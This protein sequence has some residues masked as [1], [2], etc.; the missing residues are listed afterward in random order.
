MRLRPVLIALAAL[1]ALAAPI[2]I[3]IGIVG[4][5]GCP[6]TTEQATTTASISPAPPPAPSP[7]MA[8]TTPSLD[9][10]VEPE[11]A[12]PEPLDASFEDVSA[13]AP[14]DALADGDGRA[15]ADAAGDAPLLGAKTFA[16]ETAE[17]GFRYVT[18]A[19]AKVHK[20]PKDGKAFVS[21]PKG[22][23][24]WLVARLFD[25]YRVRFVDPSTEQ[26]RQGLIYLTTGVGPRRKDCPEGWIWHDQDGGWCEREC[27][28]NTDCKALP[29][30][31]CSGTGCFYAVV[32]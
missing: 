13:D 15:H 25:W 8:A 32:E 9:E 22:T 19:A 2:V 6:A 20:A 24:V 14:T 3:P 16:D 21:L 17:S 18:A 1:A 4:L 31:K 23:Q 28:R 26:A 10:P 12:G 27:S 5:G 11:S 29:G 30:Y 7:T